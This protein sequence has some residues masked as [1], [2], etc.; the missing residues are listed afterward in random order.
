MELSNAECAVIADGV[1]EAVQPKGSARP[2]PTER[3][4]G[5]RQRAALN[6]HFR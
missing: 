4:G 1:I 5:M 3:S 2:Y 6:R